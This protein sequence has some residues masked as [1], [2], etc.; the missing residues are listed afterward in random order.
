MDKIADNMLLNV[1]SSE[2]KNFPRV[3]F[4]KGLTNLTLL[5]HDEWAGVAFAL[6]LIVNSEQGV[7]LVLAV[8]ER[9]QKEALKKARK[10][11]D[12][13]ETAAPKAKKV[14]EL[15]SSEEEGSVSGEDEDE[16]SSTDDDRKP[17]AVQLSDEQLDVSD[18]EYF[19]LPDDES[20][21]ELAPEMVI[22]PMDFLF[23][24]ETMLSFHA[25]CKTAFPL[26]FEKTADHE[27]LRKAMG[28]FLHD[29]MSS[30]PRLAGA[31]WKLQKLH[32][33]L[34]LTMNIL[35]FG[36]P[37][38]CDT[39]PN[40]NNLITFAK[41]PSKNSRKRQGEF[42]K[43]LNDR[44]C[45]SANVRKAFSFLNR[46]FHDETDS[47]SD[48]EVT[49]ESTPLLGRGALRTNRHP[50]YEVELVDGQMIASELVGHPLYQLLFLSKKR[51]QGCGRAAPAVI[52][53]WLSRKPVKGNRNMHP[54][55][56]EYFRK[57]MSEPNSGYRNVDSL[58][59]CTEYK[60]DG[61]IFRAHPNHRSNGPW[62]DWVMLHCEPDGRPQS[63]GRPRSRRHRL[64][65]NRGSGYFGNDCYP[66]KL[67]C[68][69]RHP[70]SN[71]IT[72][73]GHCCTHTDHKFDSS[74]MERW[75]LCYT[76]KGEPILCEFPVRSFGDRALVVEDRPVASE[77]EPRHSLP[78]SVTLAKPRKDYWAT[79]F[80]EES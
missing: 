39:G 24:L 5:T 10:K 75:S 44:L 11:A 59:C 62:C 1:H 27:R 54:I 52:A 40:E 42:L 34:H 7:K 28:V 73:L 30:I 36:S 56:L 12:D 64:T 20:A 66:T 18:D 35:F 14:A 41:D 2:R 33:M 32:D 80:H 37:A 47:E 50:N 70:L 16:G 71:A 13:N 67:L 79:I 45:E 60:R 77:V 74:L 48:C 51:R 55:A 61:K 43:L 23:V 49:D 29:I 63:D 3:G 31:G 8:E 6:A 76:T 26:P 22:D 25:W 15:E 69:F 4:S 19:F 46:E 21:E 57:Q 17:P 53:N 65:S 72:A 58:E 38:N 78:A 9:L 68:F